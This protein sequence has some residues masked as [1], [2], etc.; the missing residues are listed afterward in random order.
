MEQRKI[1]EEIFKILFE[2]ELVSSNIFER[3]KQFLE[4]NK[5]SNSKEEF[6]NRFMKE[7]S[8]NEQELVTGLKKYLKTWS[9]ERL[10]VVEKVLLKMSY[11]EIVLKKEEYEIV[12]NEAV[13]LAKI[14]GDVKTRQFIN[15]VLA[16]LVK[17]MR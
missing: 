14:Y 7:Y 17:E 4:E 12:I 16:D 6:I 9:F 2:H 10:G 15:G 3:T 13:E 11:Y 1:R 8:E 5:L